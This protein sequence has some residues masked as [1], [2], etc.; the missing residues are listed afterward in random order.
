MKFTYI[1]LL[2]AVSF[3][4]CKNDKGIVKSLPEVEEH[5][6]AL[7]YAEGFKITAFN[8]RKTLEIK[9]AWPKA[10]KKYTYLLLIKYY[11]SFIYLKIFYYPIYN[12]ETTESKKMFYL[13]LVYGRTFVKCPAFALFYL[14]VAY[15][16]MATTNTPRTTNS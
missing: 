8:D 11:N 4:S 6:N 9:K 12:Y 7:K 13:K 14:L 16:T 15:D 3:M 2:L 1:F 10:D 5:D